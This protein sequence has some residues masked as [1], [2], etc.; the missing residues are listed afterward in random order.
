MQLSHHKLVDLTGKTPLKHLPA[1]ISKARLLV[2]NDTM[3]VHIG[4]ALGV[5]VVVISQMNHYGR[6]VPYPK[7]KGIVMEC[8]I[9]LDFQKEDK[10]LLT[11]RFQ[12]GSEVD[13]NLITVDQVID[14]VERTLQGNSLVD[15]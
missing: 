12:N 4:A 13:I 5:P 7:E 2:T 1:V 8:V 11:E 15:N 9:P 14:A 3:A 6:F 10:R